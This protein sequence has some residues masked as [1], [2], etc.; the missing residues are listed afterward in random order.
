MIK[1][2]QADVLSRHTPLIVFSR[3]H[4]T[5]NEAQKLNPLTK[6]CYDLEDNQF[7]GKRLNNAQTN[8][9]LMM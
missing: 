3:T 1:G 6:V 7:K 4:L 2:K 5:N 9:P 8:L